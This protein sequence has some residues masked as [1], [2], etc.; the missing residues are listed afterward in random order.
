MPDP[1]ETA[2]RC[3]RA[4][5]LDASQVQGLTGASGSTFS[6]GEYVLRIGRRLDRE[7]A[8]MSAAAG[9]VPVPRVLDRVHCED[10][11]GALLERLPGRPAGELASADPAHAAH[12]GRACGALHQLVA[13][14]GAPQGVP[15]IDA[16]SAGSPRRLL[17]LDLHPFNVLVDDGGEVTGVIDWANAAAGH[18]VLDR[19]RTWSILTLDPSV[20][21]RHSPG[22]KDLC[23][24]WIA[25]GGLGTLPGDARAWAAGFMIRD[26]QHRH[27]E[28]E[29]SPIRQA[30]AAAETRSP[31]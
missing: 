2:R 28:A 15:A 17:H 9:V 21:R 7:I 14:V 19:S 24:A 12:A 8:A 22:W 23:T 20:R 31:T 30:L 10:L 29:L 1:L 16:L 11:D 6:V 18:P 25:E 27:A 26:L 4:L 13:A 5:G 3:A